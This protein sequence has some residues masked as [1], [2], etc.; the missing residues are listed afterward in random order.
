MKK[1]LWLLLIAV[2]LWASI[3]AGCILLFPRSAEADEYNAKMERLINIRRQ[4]LESTSQMKFLAGWEPMVVFGIPSDIHPAR[5]YDFRG[6]YD[7]AVRAFT[8]H[9][10]YYA[11]LNRLTSDDPAAV[12]S[13]FTREGDLRSVIDHELGH[14]LVHD[15]ALRA[16]QARWF[17]SLT[18]KTMTADERIGLTML[19]EGISAYFERLTSADRQPHGY[20]NLPGSWSD[21]DWQFNTARVINEGGYWIV[22]PI[23]ERFGEQGIVYLLSHQLRLPDGRADDA[24]LKYQRLALII[25]GGE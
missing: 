7:P 2:I 6:R 17:N 21:T 12:E 1:F 23:I 16:G 15:I 25:L 18:I 4:A 22:F 8:F 14:A 3:I 10:R 13:F 9:P 19:A 20:G 11:A 24:G 5:T